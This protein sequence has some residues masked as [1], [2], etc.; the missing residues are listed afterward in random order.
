MRIAVVVHGYPPV[1]CAGVE[2]VAKEQA[3][4]LAARGHAVAVFARTLDPSRA[5]GDTA[6]EL[7]DGIR[8][9]RVVA[10]HGPRDS[11]LDYEDTLRF[12]EAFRIFLAEHRPDVV[13]VQHTIL[14]SPNLLR[15]AREAGAA[16]VLALHDAYY[17]CHRIFLLD[18]DGRRC[19]GPELGARCER[20][21]SD[22][23][24]PGEPRARFDFMARALDVPHVL[25]APSHA[26]AARYAE[27]LP[28]LAGR[29]TVVE[30]GIEPVRTDE[31]A[32]RRR[33]VRTAA[34]PLRLLFIGTWLPHKGLDLLIDAVCA[35]DP[36]RYELSIRGGGVAGREDYVRDLQARTAGRPVRW[37]GAFA[38]DELPAILDAADA[39]V[40]PS[41]C[42]E[43][44]SRVVREAR[45]AG[46]AV[47]APAVGGPSEAL[48]HERDA[49][50]VAPDD[51]Q[52]LRA[53]LERLVSDV[54]LGARLAAAPAVFPDVATGVARLEGVF[55]DARRRASRAEELPS[56]TVAYVTKN[57]APWLEA[58]L[59][60]V[61]AQR[62]PFRL[63]EILA[64]DSGSTDGTLEILAR[65]GVR[66]RRIAPH[67]FGHGRTRNLAV[68]EAAGDV[69]AFLTQDATPADDGWLTG[70]VAA[71][72]H[73][74]LLAGVWSR[75]A[76]RPDCH[77]MEWRMLA[78]FPLFRGHDAH[79]PPVVS[80]AR[81]N[82][83]YASNPE[84]FYWFSNNAAAFRRDV[85]LRWP[86]PEVDFAEDQA[87]ARRVLEAGFRTA[88]VPSS[89]ILH[90][91]A[92]S[93]W[94]NLQRNF[95]HA[96][97]M[98]DDLGQ[99]DDLTL[100]D[101]LRAAWRESRRD[102]A[103][104]ADFR[105]RTRARVAVRW[106]LRALAYHLGAFGGRW[107]GAHARHLPAGLSG[108]LSQHE[109]VRAGG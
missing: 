82:P 41:R 60:A 106:G 20:C 15:V 72:R 83:E 51:A 75:H 74:P 38:A 29:I 55:D 19:A 34:D 40:L 58:S 87:W 69:I 95:D 31:A 37:D 53:A 46:L 65:N 48:T 62:G 3:E 104:W 36:A 11:F 96:R 18:R 103:F 90:S 94:S 8:V 56:V 47:I 71:L 6:D 26:L 63:V 33:A 16:T 57:G 100:G 14:L 52:Q 21:L 7:V 76:P 39:L 102:V 54:A 50:L 80:A 70:L 17:L 12:D 32:R 101:A 107:L 109:R 68:R 85:L 59:Q 79:A 84:R 73:D 22:V 10:N 28:F 77:P 64:I 27:S 49:L 9:R 81:G 5:D 98:H 93:A 25:V 88:L 92:Y 23:A 42:D 24:R 1:E 13:H 67:E 44:Y 78:E 45:S 105:R 61:R 4:A 86:L 43:S 99:S 2:L 97:A 30:P 91:H 108:R 89:L 35:L 66:I